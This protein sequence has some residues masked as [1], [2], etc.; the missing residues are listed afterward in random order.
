MAEQFRAAGL[1]P[2]GIDGYR[3]PMDFHVVQ[4]DEAHCALDLLREGKAQPL[5]LGEDAVFAINSHAAENVEAG[6]VFVG[7]GLT[8]PELHYNDL[9]GQ[10]VKGKIVVFITGGPSDM[11]GPVKAHYQST[12]E[13]HR[14]LEK[15]GVIGTISIPNP[16]SAEVPWS[17]I[18]AARFQPRMELSDPG[19][20]VPHPLPLGIAFNP[21]HAEILFTGSGHSF[22]EIL[23]DLNADKPLPHFPLAVTIRARVP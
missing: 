15:A 13:R 21:A 16:R 17:R 2:A 18:A 20:D 5:Q 11:A 9:A 1:E 23:A 12:E 14:A 19:H 22:Q 8:V 7:Y 6:A 3:Q 10:D 4:I